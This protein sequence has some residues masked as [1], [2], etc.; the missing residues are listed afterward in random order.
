MILTGCICNRGHVY[1]TMESA[2]MVGVP[3]VDNQQYRPEPSDWGLREPWVPLRTPWYSIKPLQPMITGIPAHASSRA[4]IP[5]QWLPYYRSSGLYDSNSGLRACP[6]HLHRR[7]LPGTRSPM[8]HGRH[9]RCASD[10][11]TSRSLPRR[12]EIRRSLPIWWIVI[13]VNI[14]IISFT[15]IWLRLMLN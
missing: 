1:G 4:V 14:I 8:A 9:H 10:I 11:R 13:Q 6:A 5:G 12:R 15:L 7:A 2:A 3:L